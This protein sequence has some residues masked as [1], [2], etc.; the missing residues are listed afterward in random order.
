MVDHELKIQPIYFNPVWNEEKTFEIRENDRD[1]KV[2]DIVRL[3][4]WDL[5]NCE[6][7]GRSLLVIIIYITDFMQ[8]PGYIV[9]GFKGCW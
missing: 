1:F 3:R 7:T 5:V 6:Y 4:E 8:K 9:F 2:G